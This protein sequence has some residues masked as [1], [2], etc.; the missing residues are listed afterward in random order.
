MQKLCMIFRG[1]VTLRRSVVLEGGLTHSQANLFHE[2]L[3]LKTP[4][5]MILWIIVTKS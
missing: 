2:V 5:A 1:V 3:S 4:Q